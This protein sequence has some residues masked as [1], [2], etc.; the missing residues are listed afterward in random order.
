[1]A[2]VSLL[3]LKFSSIVA[4]WDG[5]KNFSNVRLVVKTSSPS[6][7]R[8]EVSPLGGNTKY[9]HSNVEYSAIRDRLKSKHCV[10]ADGF[11][12]FKNY[13]PFA[14]FKLQRWSKNDAGLGIHSTFMKPLL[15]YYKTL[16]CVKNTEMTRDL[17]GGIISYVND[18]TSRAV[19]NG[20][21][22]YIDDVIRQFLAEV[23]KLT[24]VLCQQNAGNSLVYSSLHGL[25]TLGGPRGW[26]EDSVLASLKDWVT[27]ERKFPYE[28]D[29]FLNAKLDS[30]I[31]EWSRNIKNDDLSFSEFVS[32]PMRWATGGGAKKKQ[33]N[34]RGRQVDGRNKWFWALSGLSKGEDL[35]Q[36]GLDEGN[37]AQV[38]LKEEAKTRCVITTP[39]AS[40]L[41]QCYMLYRFGNPS[42]LRSTLSSPHLVSE[43]SRSRK[44]H[45][46]CIDSSSF[47][48]SVSKKW[49]LS[50]L[51]RMA[52]RCRGELR[53][54]IISEM[55]SLRDMSI[56]YNNH[57]L[58]YENGLLSG[59]RMTS[60]LGSMLSALVCE[61]I[62]HSMMWK[63]PYIVQGDD[64]IMM[65]PRKV[66]AERVL[67]CC[68]RFGI[69]TNKKK[70]TI[71]RFGEFL[72]YRYGY[73]RVQGYAAR[74]VRS[75]FY[76]NPWLDSTAVGAASE[77]SG[78]WWTLLSRLMNSHNGGFKDEESL[79]WFMN[80]IAS[81][82]GG[83]LG[84]RVS[85]SA[86]LDAIKTPVSLGG[87]GVFETAD[88]N[89]ANNN[90]F[91]TKITSIVQEDSFGDSKFVSL[92]APDVLSKVGKVST[93]FVDVKKIAMN[94]G[95]DL[96][97]FKSKYH[98]I[99]NTAGRVVFDSGS[100]IFRTVL[101]EIA[102]CR[103]YPPIV[104]RL[105]S[106][107]KGKCSSIVRPRF[108][109]NSNRWYDV[110]KWLTEI[111]LKADCPPSLFVDTRYDNELVQSLAG[112][113]V[114][115]FMNLSNVTARSE[116]LISV[117]ALFRFGHTKC[118]LHAL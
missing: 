24:F 32:D 34:I 47:D 60:L 112:V 28:N 26:T 27:G 86:L 106:S 52:D 5:P 100:N 21:F 99:V 110:A 38:A 89:L 30:W 43:L 64:I 88:I 69:I 46:I 15:F 90:G 103:N 82:V 59:W 1:M 94:F 51:Q 12:F 56:S 85:R 40:Y 63:L 62:N 37:N 92:F 73:G 108:L 109:R 76:A 4:K 45:F 111:T 96:T 87:L 42:F 77:V 22:D 74:S 13:N 71:G 39:Q 53:D 72:K 115:M 57:V 2:D 35:Y 93:R 65:C 23:D 97:E 75:I 79:E 17:L 36:V 25:S 58:K 50:V 107:V 102:S 44:D 20:M 101:S 14:L 33:M 61:F 29:R 104:D 84:G 81:D 49:V 48:H 66:S 67:E 68:S 91:I 3:H 55:D 31:D 18:L 9:V 6:D 41:R 114:T 105:L 116:Y 54:V 78:K 98:S 8:V 11:S 80:N 83:W 16:G 117:F 19:G 95:R 70:T 118:I 113:A 10:E 7:D